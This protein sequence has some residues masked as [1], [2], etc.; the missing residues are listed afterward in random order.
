MV[1]NDLDK[2]NQITQTFVIR[3]GVV[4]FIQFKQYELEMSLTN[5]TLSLVNLAN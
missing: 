1:W 4:Q 2:P 3:C 5:L